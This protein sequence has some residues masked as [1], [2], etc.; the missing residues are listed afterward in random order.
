[1][2][3]TLG[4]SAEDRLSTDPARLRL[5]KWSMDDFGEL[6]AEKLKVGVDPPWPVLNL[7]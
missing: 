4:A 1:M 5:A 2:V 6:V 3:S 7:P